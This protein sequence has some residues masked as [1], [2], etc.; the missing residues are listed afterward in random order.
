M[1]NII[2]LFFDDRLL[3]QKNRKKARSIDH[4]CVTT[5]T[6]WCNDKSMEHTLNKFWNKWTKKKFSLFFGRMQF[7]NRILVLEICGRIEKFDPK[8]SEPWWRN[9]N[10]FSP[11]SICS[12]FV[13]CEMQSTNPKSLSTK[14]YGFFFLSFLFSSF[15]H[16]MRHF[17]F[18]TLWQK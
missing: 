1:I 14:S 4:W 12:F 15:K 9:A 7:L 8:V 16:L 11:F 3:R 13:F 18:S 2:K 6:I 17:D 5:G 10:E